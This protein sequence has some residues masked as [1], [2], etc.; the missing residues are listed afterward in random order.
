MEDVSAITEST[1]VTV[2]DH[3]TSA[4]VGGEN[5]ILNLEQGVYYGLNS[6]GARIWELIQE[7]VPVCHV[8][9]V[10]TSEY[11]VDRDRCARDVLQLL[12]D[13]D[14]QALIEVE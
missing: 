3:Q 14:K 2:V 13:L 6:V 7:P 1:V 5:V 4:Q 9:E 12:R 11:D 8:I 10:M